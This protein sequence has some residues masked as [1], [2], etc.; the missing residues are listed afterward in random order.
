MIVRMGMVRGMGVSAWIFP[1]GSFHSDE[2]EPDLLQCS[3]CPHYQFRIRF[4]EYINMNV[5]NICTYVHTYIYIYIC[6]YVYTYIYIYILI[7]K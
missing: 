1:R 7:N 5:S 6:I 4:P 2:A 3:S